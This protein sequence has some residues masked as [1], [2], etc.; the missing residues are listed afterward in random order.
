VAPD[1]K[2]PYD[3][4]AAGA[5]TAADVED[6]ATAVLRRLEEHRARTGR[7]GL[8]VV[9]YDTELFGHWW[10]EGPQF[11]E[12]VLR[13]LP[14]L[15]VQLSTLDGARHGHVAST[16]ALSSGSWGAGKDWHIWTDQSA[17]TEQGTRVADRLLR[18]VDKRFAE[19][20]GERDPRYDQL[21]REALLT[22][23]SDWAF[24]VSH[25][26]SPDYARRRAG[27]HAARFDELADRLEDG[28]GSAGGTVATAGLVA[29]LRRI[30]GPFGTLDARALLDRDRT[31][32]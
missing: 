9:A 19:G 7:A 30:D 17:L 20:R 29:R 4:A 23:S 18:L 27:E 22:L 16:R 12:G 15:G 26:S 25:D 14:E 10:H 11:L 6:F 3:A 2:E 8:V 13:R 1:E 24:L 31:D 28:L 21:T 32:E 5:A